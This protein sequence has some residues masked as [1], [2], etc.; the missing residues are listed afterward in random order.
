[1]K[2]SS[3]MWRRLFASGLAAL[4]IFTAGY[5][6]ARGGAGQPKTVRASAWSREASTMDL[7]FE[8]RNRAAADAYA[9]SP[10]HKIWNDHYLAVR[11]ASVA[12]DVTNN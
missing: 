11:A 6:V 12:I 9:S 7:R 8:F 4:A 1:M 5:V 2:I 10:L 3:G